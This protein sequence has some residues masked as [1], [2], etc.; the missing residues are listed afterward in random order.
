MLLP[1]TH[2]ADR[3]LRSMPPPI[4]AGVHG[5]QGS[6]CRRYPSSARPWRYGNRNLVE[7]DAAADVAGQCGAGGHRRGRGMDFH[8]T[9]RRM[10]TDLP[11]AGILRNQ[12]CHANHAGIAVLA[13]GAPVRA[14]RPVPADC[15]QL[16]Q[17]LLR[18][19]PR[20][21]CGTRGGVVR[22]VGIVFVGRTTRHPARGG[23]PRGPARRHRGS[24]HPRTR[25]SGRLW[26]AAEAGVDV[27][28]HRDGTRLPMR[29][30]DRC[31]HRILVAARGRR[32]LPAGR[33]VLHRR[34]TSVRIRRP[35]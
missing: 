15:R 12:S 27:G 6:R 13:V 23:R 24:P 26:R 28:R 10:R 32:V 14:G 5:S 33:L 30:G 9:A 34:S 11:R 20:H 22:I 31:H 21:G 3:L 4:A 19:H 7:G 29:S 2:T 18:W 35:G 25:A 1:R 8:P 16:C 17:R